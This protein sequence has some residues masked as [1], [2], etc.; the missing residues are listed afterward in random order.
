MGPNGLGSSGPGQ[1]VGSSAGNVGDSSDGGMPSWIG[2]L[3]AGIFG[4][5]GSPY[6]AA[7]NAYNKY[8]QMGANAIDP[9]N[10][11]GQSAMTNYANWAKG[12][13][14]PAAF[15][16]SLMSQYQESPQAKFMQ[17]QALRSAQNAGSAAG[18]V[19]S[20][21]YALQNEQ[22]AANISQQDMGNW[23]NN[24][25]GI[26]TQYG[27]AQ[28][29]MMNTGEQ[30]ANSLLNLYGN[31]ADA[32]ANAAYGQQAGKNQDSGNFI[33]GLLGAAGSFLGL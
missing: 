2:D 6:S 13:S 32:Q 1:N 14:N 26:N 10:Q 7:G 18:T 28:N 22:N 33:S 31:E 11:M 27:A 20:T 23:L 5:S 17:Q 29:N 21:P 19:G 25:L 12:M 24:A 8:A 15:E 16:N 9:Y 30:G 4:N 3:F